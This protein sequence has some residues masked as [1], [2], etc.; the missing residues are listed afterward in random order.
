MLTSNS[1]PA[2]IGLLSQW[3]ATQEWVY[4]KLTTNTVGIYT[5]ANFLAAQ[6]YTLSQAESAYEFQD[7][8]RY[9]V[10]GLSDISGPE[11]T[12]VVDQDGV[13]GLHGVPQMPVYV[14][15]AINDQIS[16]VAD[17]DALVASFCEQGANILYQRNTVGSHGTEEINGDPAATLFLDAVLTGTYADSYST[18]GC[19]IQNVTV[20]TSGGKW[21]HKSR[22]LWDA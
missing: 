15:K 20:Q 14:Y 21:G 6:N 18:T 12:A 1:Q 4:S 2:I 16:P 13:M 22:T 19:T 11:V 17:T 10:D 7:I 8:Y 3:P 9:F 5:A